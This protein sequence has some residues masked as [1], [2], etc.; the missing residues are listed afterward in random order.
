MH[1]ECV[2]GTAGNDSDPD[3]SKLQQED[4]NLHKQYTEY[5]DCDI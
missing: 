1:E 4:M 5:T 2:I 3:D